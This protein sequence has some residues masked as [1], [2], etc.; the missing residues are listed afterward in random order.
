MSENDSFELNEDGEPP[1]RVDRFADPFYIAIQWPRVNYETGQ[2][3]NP[4]FSEYIAIKALTADAEALI[5]DYGVL[6]GDDLVDQDV[7]IEKSHTRL[8]R[9]MSVWFDH[10]EKGNR[11]PVKS[12]AY[13]Y[14]EDLPDGATYIRFWDNSSVK[15][16]HSPED[17]VVETTATI[18]DRM[19]YN[20]GRR[21]E[22][23][24]VRFG[25][26]VLRHIFHR[27]RL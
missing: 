9:R 11:V 3:Y 26:K 23:P 19:L 25:K 21:A 2:T 12:Y 17:H 27:S 13:F 1:S 8:R 18:H 24:K 5:A 20:L 22:V 6:T 4:E 10:D 15:V 7:V 14:S 16:H